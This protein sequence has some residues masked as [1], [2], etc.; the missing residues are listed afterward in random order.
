[1]ETSQ[2]PE[3]DRKYTATWQA[4]QP[5][6]VSMGFVLF[7][8]KFKN[9][10]IQFYTYR[11]MFL[12]MPTWFLKNYTVC[13]KEKQ[14]TLQSDFSL[15]GEGGKSARS[16]CLAL[17]SGFSFESWTSSYVIEQV[18]CF[19]MP[20]FSSSVK[21]EGILSTWEVLRLVPHTC[22]HSRNV[23]GSFIICYC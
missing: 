17:N 10:H 21:W 19:S 7:G 2:T 14:Q 12:T 3:S 18:T 6:R 20:Q 13:L 23:A 11:V 8:P 1:M 4:V 9:A 22:K 5:L 16:D 15:W